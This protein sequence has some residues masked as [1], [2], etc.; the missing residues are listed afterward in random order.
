MPRQDSGPNSF[1][2]NALAVTPAAYPL[3][4]YKRSGVDEA[5][6]LL[7]SSAEPAQQKDARWFRHYQVLYLQ[8]EKQGSPK[9]SPA[10]D[11][12]ALLNFAHQPDHHCVR[13]PGNVCHSLTQI[14]PPR[15]RDIVGVVGLQL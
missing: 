1:A 4:A 9:A 2:S 13:L 10:P 7:P 12:E 3:G 14:T 8:R 11:G 15:C 5:A 6:G